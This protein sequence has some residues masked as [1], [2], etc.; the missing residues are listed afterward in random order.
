MVL[1]SNTFQDTAET[2]G[3]TW[4]RQRG[5]EAISVSWLDYN[6]DGLVDLW[7]SGHGTSRSL[8]CSRQIPRKTGGTKSHLQCLNRNSMVFV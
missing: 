1:Q 5:D 6:S 2:A 3:I 7:I 4:S 8:E